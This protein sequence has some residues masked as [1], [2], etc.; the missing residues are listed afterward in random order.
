MLEKNN[1]KKHTTRILQFPQKFLKKKHLKLK[2]D[3]EIPVRYGRT[4]STKIFF[5]STI[6]QVSC[7]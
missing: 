2:K 7:A 3:K 6:P 5:R 1:L 4:R